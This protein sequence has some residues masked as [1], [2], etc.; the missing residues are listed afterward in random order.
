MPTEFVATNAASSGIKLDRKTLKWIAGRSDRPG[1]LFLGQWGLAL[2]ATGC[3][4]YLSMDTLWL[5]PAMLVHG[6]VLT[7]PAYA[8]GHETVHGTAFRSRWINTAMAWLTG[9]IYMEEPLHRLY[10][11]TNHHT[12]TWHAGKDSQMPF[13]TPLAFGGWLMEVSGLALL[14]FHLMT[15][16]RLAAGRYS[17]VMRMVV[18]ESEFAK[19]TRNAWVFVAVYTGIGV[20]VA[21]GAH[22]W[23]YFLVLPRLLGGPAMLL[24][25][26][27]QHVEMAENSP[28][29][30]E[31]TRSFRT[32]RI[33]AFLYMNMNHH[34]EHH[35][36][37]QVPFHALPAL[38]EALED[39]LPEPDPGFIRTSREV[40]SVVL[41]RS[42]GHSTRASS[43]RQA[44]HMVTEG[45]YRKLSV[46]AMK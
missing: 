21:S 22:E 37:P 12:C 26:L 42:L 32:N 9:L 28:S 38:H 39:Q 11:H 31:S 24:L 13:D 16:L 33:L 27:M 40:V 14:H 15:L 1:L 8:L 35:L 41:R 4:V 18:P 7:V 29:I 10:T 20:D 19:L 30:L 17:P 3:L 23:L 44:P 6:V 46:R 34:I 2:L 45:G 43:I 5:W 25:G 36:Y